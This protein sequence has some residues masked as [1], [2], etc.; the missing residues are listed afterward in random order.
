M[1]DKLEKLKRPVDST[2]E[3]VQTSKDALVAE[4]VITVLGFVG[5]FAFAN[6]PAPAAACLIAAT[7]SA[8]AG[9]SNLEYQNAVTHQ[10]PSN[11]KSDL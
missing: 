2:I 4:C 1:I 3:R 7:C 6:K 8:M 11:Y 10:D 9:Y 5:V